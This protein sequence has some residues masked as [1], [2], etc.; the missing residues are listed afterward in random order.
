MEK[1]TLTRFEERCIQEEPAFCTA[2]CPF[3]VDVKTFMAHMAKNAVDKAFKV[4]EKSLPLPEILS[5]TCDHPCEAA[6]IRTS[7]D[8]ALAVGSLE[9]ACARARTRQKKYFSLPPK[10]KAVGIWGSGPASLAAAWDLS[11]KGYRV[12]VFEHQDQLGG[13]LA[14]LD[15]DVLPWTVLDGEIQR[16]RKFGANFITGTD[17]KAFQDRANEFHALFIG[18]DADGGPGLPQDIENIDLFSLRFGQSHTF[19]GGFSLEGLA[20][21]ARHAPVSFAFQGRKAATSIDR[22]LSGVSL[23]AG[24]DREGPFATRLD[25]DLSRVS[26]MPGTGLRDHLDAAGADTEIDPDI[27]AQEAARCH[28]CDCSRCIRACNTYMEAFNGFPG[29]YAR[30]IYNNL[31]IVMGE[32]KANTLINSCTLCGLCQTVCPN[33]FSMADLCLQARQEMNREKRMPASAHEFAL[34]EMA[35]AMTPD[36]FFAGHAPG[37]DLSKVLFFPG[38]Q[39]TGSSPAQA[40]MAYEWLKGQEPAT[41]IV[42]GCC[43][44][45]AHWAGKSGLFREMQDTFTRLW[46]DWGRPHVITACTACSRM[47][48]TGI[49]QEK[50]Q[51]LYRVM[52][53]AGLA[54]AMV[55]QGY[56]AAVADPC[57]ARE[58]RDVRSAVR[59]LA[60][61]A[62]ITINEL[63]A[64]GE[65]TECC[66]FGGLT[67]NANPDMARTIIRNRA[68]QSDHDYIAYCAMCRDRL[69]REGKTAR[70]ILDLF[71]PDTEDPGPGHQHDARPDP[72]FSRRR[73]NR[74]RFRADLAAGRTT[75]STPVPDTTTPSGKSVVVSP[76]LLAS[77]EDRFILLSDVRAVLSQFETNGLPFF[78]HVSR[79]TRITCF[80][81]GTVCFWVEFT[82]TDDEFRVRDAWAHRMDVVPSTARIP[83]KVSDDHDPDI[84]CGTCGSA[85]EFYKSHVAYLGSK[86]DVDLPQCPDCGT[87]FISSLLSQTRMAEVEQI[88]EDK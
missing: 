63:E 40:A 88:L 69:A 83:G 87:V 37:Q 82:D 55:Q 60:T 86:F 66:G 24:R 70:H 59:D 43:G 2:A 46:E 19:Y 71:W 42:T 58:D 65:F 9:Q 38:C 15:P 77:I 76:A 47:L 22:V 57:T 32:R 31:S 20:V 74:A 27:A 51:S 61:A 53:H 50:I 45:P 30:E 84:R 79:K 75:P 21:T 34:A 18:L 78:S 62:G 64:S 80:R 54:P 81:P 7:V 73:M 56:T 48:E 36:C 49:P 41:G 72:G 29:R 13:H 28:Q 33:D 4:L 44:A 8:Q 16:L 52:A 5:R 14:R 11:L 68:A 26:P 1:Q 12:T 25:T 10:D 6:C 23:D 17:F 3:H 39:L 35:H 85:L 67:F